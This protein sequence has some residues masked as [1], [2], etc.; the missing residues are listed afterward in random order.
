[1]LSIPNFKI[2]EISI[3]SVQEYIAI[4]NFYLGVGCFY[5]NR[6]D[7][8]LVFRLSTILAEQIPS[9]EQIEYI[10]GYSI[11]MIENAAEAVLDLI[12]E[13]LTPEQAVAQTLKES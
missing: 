11:D 1:M 12:N 7:N 8:M 13:K 9:L 4:M 2:P 10:F 6:E 5:F 3:A